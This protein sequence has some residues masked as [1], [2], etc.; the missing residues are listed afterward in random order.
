MR[1]TRVVVALDIYLQR[2]ECMMCLGARSSGRRFTVAR[3]LIAFSLTIPH[4][5]A[6]LAQPG[7]TISRIQTLL[8]F[9]SFFSGSALYCPFVNAVAGLCCSTLIIER[10]D[11]PD[12]LYAIPVLLRAAGL[13]HTASSLALQPVTLW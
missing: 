2:L 9:Y 1:T 13:L 10:G 3:L 11:S 12:D 4:S 5:C 6:L 7:G 8:A